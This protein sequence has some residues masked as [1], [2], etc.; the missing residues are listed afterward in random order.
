VRDGC[1]LWSSRCRQPYAGLSQYSWMWHYSFAP[2]TDV[3][4]PKYTCQQPVCCA[5][6][7]CFH[8]PAS[9]A[10]TSIVWLLILHP[11]CLLQ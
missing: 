8:M 11:R 1:A 9:S 7:A 6:T 10:T 5:F 3:L 4:L 2:R